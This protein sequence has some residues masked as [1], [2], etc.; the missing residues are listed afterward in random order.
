MNDREAFTG[1]DGTFELTRELPEGA[2]T[3][4]VCSADR[5]GAAVMELAED[6][7]RS[8]PLKIKLVKTVTV[9]GRVYDDQD[10]PVPHAR[11]SLREKKGN[12]DRYL[13]STTADNE[14]KYRLRGFVLPEQNHHIKVQA[15]VEYRPNRMLQMHGH[16]LEPL[17]PGE[18]VGGLNFRITSSESAVTISA[19]RE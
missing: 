6:A 10:K 19:E 12:E 15:D 5:N 9:T 18:E 2:Y 17:Q 8:V 7:D 11:V 16:D 3:I 13:L 1:L 4:W 14:G